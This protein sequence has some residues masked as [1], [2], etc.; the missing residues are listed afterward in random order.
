MKRYQV[1]SLRFQFILNEYRP[2]SDRWKLSIELLSL[3]AIKHE[4]QDA[5]Y[6]LNGSA[7]L[8]LLQVAKLRDIARVS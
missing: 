1:S 7:R 5:G 3:K 2:D 8:P 4:W 6:A